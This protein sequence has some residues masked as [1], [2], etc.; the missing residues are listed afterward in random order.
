[1][2]GIFVNVIN[3]TFTLPDAGRYFI[4]FSINLTA[5]VLVS[6]RV[7]IN[8]IP[9]SPLTINP[10]ISLSSYSAIAI[11]S[12]SAGDT[13]TLQLFGLLGAITLLS[14]SQGAKL[15]IIRLS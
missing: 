4:S 3:D 12:I 5:A 6:S 7:L 9:S 14:S 10:V 13:L 1:M 11:L 8:R 2:G 15:T